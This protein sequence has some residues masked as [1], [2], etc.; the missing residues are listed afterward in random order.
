MR[1]SP[2]IRLGPFEVVAPLGAGGMGEVYRARD[3]RLGRDIALKLLPTELAS[4]PDRLARFER[5]ARTVAGLAHPNIVSLFS[6]E[7]HDGTKFL[8]LELVEGRDLTSVVTRQGLPLAQVL[9]IAIPLADALVAAHE[10]GIV[11]RDLKPANVMV[12]REGRVKVLDFGLAKAVDKDAHAT[13]AATIS[14]VG[15]VLGTVAYMAPEQIRGEAVDARTD[16]FAFGIVLYELATGARPFTGES[17][18]DITSSILRDT[19]KPLRN[20]RS[21]LPPDLERIVERL[22]AKNP[23]E[24]FQTA[25]DV[26]MEL[27]RIGKAPRAKSI[28]EKTVSVAVLPFANR[29]ASA[30]DEYF[31]EG[32]ADELLGVLG[33]IRGLRVAARSSAARFKGGAEDPGTVGRALNVETILEGS[34]RKAGNRVRIGVQ[35]VKAADGSMMWSETYDRTFDDVFAVQDDIAQSVVKALRSAL[36]GEAPDSDASRDARAEVAEAVRGRTTNPEVLRLILQGRHIAERRTEG[37]ISRGIEYLER[38]VEL[39]PDYAPAFVALCQAHSFK[40]D[41]VPEPE[42]TRE[43]ERAQQALDR[44][45]ALAPDLPEVHAQRAWLFYVISMDWKRAHGS[46]ERALSLD[47]K[48]PVVL[49]IAGVIAKAVG[50]HE[51]SANFFRRMLELDPLSPLGHQNLGHVLGLAGKHEEAIAFLRRTLELSPHSA[52]TGAMLAYSLLA[53]DQKEEAL[54]E[55]RA[56]A[57]EIFRLYGVSLVLWRMGRK[58]ESDQKLKD[59]IERWSGVAAAQIAELHALHGDLDGAFTWIDRAIEARDGGIME[60]GGMPQYSVLHSDPRWAAF[61]KRMNYDG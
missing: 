10:K 2:G 16:L 40:G 12:S 43:Y 41:I 28:E 5:E 58:E 38:A 9:D 56:D 14:D 59:L 50:H 18:A 21:E 1:L 51:E 7:E 61:R 25:L 57:H 15:Q 33:R 24:R 37:D 22:L 53:L 47:P 32:L 13:V 6:I 45:A 42:R 29:S 23:R 44:A 34:V 39:D 4:N 55:A 46:I 11:H 48:N 30:D 20:V 49:R 31:A 19:P 60:G 36:L 54:A 8:I 26:L 27:K 17:S 52:G 3:T 35:L